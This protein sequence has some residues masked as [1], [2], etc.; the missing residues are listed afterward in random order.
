MEGKKRIAL[1]HMAKGTCVK[2]DEEVVTG[3]VTRGVEQREIRG[4]RRKRETWQRA[5]R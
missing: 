1:A 2:E 3:S 5:G 4:R